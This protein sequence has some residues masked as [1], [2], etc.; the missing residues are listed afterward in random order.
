MFYLYVGT[1]AA[2][3]SWGTAAVVL[4]FEDHDTATA[5]ATAIKALAPNSIRTVVVPATAPPPPPPPPEV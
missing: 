5:A 1:F 3:A 2:G 4:T